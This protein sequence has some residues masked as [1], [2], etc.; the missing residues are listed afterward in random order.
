VPESTLESAIAVAERDGLRFHLRVRLVVLT[1][2]AVWLVATYARSRVVPGLVVIAA[3]AAFGIA[4]YALGRRYGHPILWAGVSTVF[5]VAL[6]IAVVLTPITF[7]SDWP[8]QMQL[9]L[10]AVF[11]LFVYV[12]GTVLSYSRTLVVWTGALTAAAWGVGHQIMLRM[13]DTITVHGR[14]IDKPWLSSTRSLAR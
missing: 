13:P 10:P 9:R 5:E 3:F 11:Y 8:P 2:L 12:A 4:Q 14:L 7:P 6:L 1:A